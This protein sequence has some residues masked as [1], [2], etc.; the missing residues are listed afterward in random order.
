MSARTIPIPQLLQR[1]VVVNSVNVSVMNSSFAA[2]RRRR[3]CQRGQAPSR[4]FY[5]TIVIVN[6]NIGVLNFPSRSFCSI[7][8]AV[9]VKSAWPNPVTQLLQRR[10]RRQCRCQRDRLPL[11]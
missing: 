8:V 7:I 10:R 11:A 6:V 9:S 3:Q 5:I 4:S 2:L 1:V